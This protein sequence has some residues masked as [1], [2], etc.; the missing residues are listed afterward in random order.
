MTGKT[1]GL[2]GALYDYYAAHA[3]REP[4]LLQALRAEILISA[5][6]NTVSAAKHGVCPSP[7]G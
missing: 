4:P 7:S 3:S 5:A 1:I 6:E 2:T